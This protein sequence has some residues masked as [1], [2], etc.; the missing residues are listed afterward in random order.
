MEYDVIEN[1]ILYI[2]NA[3]PEINDIFNFLDKTSNDL[4]TKWLPWIEFGGYDRKRFFKDYGHSKSIYFSLANH[5]IDDSDYTETL[6]VIQKMIDSI[7]ESW[8][9]YKDIFKFTNPQNINKDFAILKYHDYKTNSSSSELGLHIDHPDPNNTNEHTMLIYYNNNYVGGEVIFPRIG[10]TV[11]PNAGDILMFS[12]V[13]PDLI[14]HTN[15]VT[16]GNKIFTLQLW[17]DGATKGYYRKANA[18]KTHSSHLTEG[19]NNLIVCPNCNFW[20]S[21]DEF[22]MV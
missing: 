16:E 4:I 15:A 14:H 19:A 10:V 2:K 22:K 1:K 13:D 11:S 7:D 21:H 9:I 18:P 17:Q 5:Y 6:E 3:I 8:G 20:G 12:S